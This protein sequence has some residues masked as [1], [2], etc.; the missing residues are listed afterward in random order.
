MRD[1]SYTLE[2]FTT[3]II[4]VP[5]F[6]FKFEQRVQPPVFVGR[7][8]LKNGELTVFDSDNKLVGAVNLADNPYIKMDPDTGFS[9]RVEVMTGRFLPDDPQ[10]NWALQFS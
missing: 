1:G 2:A 4:T 9:P 5:F 6:G 10:Y 8:L 7:A 3:T